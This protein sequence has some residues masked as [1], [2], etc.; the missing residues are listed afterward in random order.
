MIDNLKTMLAPF[1]PFSS[2][3]VHEYLGYDGQL[4][5]DLKIESFDETERAHRALVYDGAA[6]IGKW[7]KSNLKP[8][9][10]LRQPK[11]LYVKLEPEIVDQ[12][13]DLLGQPRDE[14]AIEG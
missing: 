6:A 9:Q 5:G 7:E 14:H 3:Q 8:G 13:R 10:A 4:F 11:A 12:E 1:L 2:Q